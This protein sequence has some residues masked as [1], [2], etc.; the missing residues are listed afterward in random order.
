M[1]QQFST[2]CRRAESSSP[3]DRKQRSQKCFYRFG[4]EGRGMH[5]AVPDRREPVQINEPAGR[6]AVE[7]KTL[8][9]C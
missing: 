8:S 9:G 1:H 3:R 4:P 5:P 6:L 2:L 7:T